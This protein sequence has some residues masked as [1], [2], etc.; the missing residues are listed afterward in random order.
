MLDY[1]PPI[2]NNPIMARKRTVK[3]TKVSEQLREAIR[4]A[5][6]SRYRISKETGIDQSMLTKFLQGERGLAIST[7]DTLAE[8]LNLE[9]TH[10]K[11]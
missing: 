10:K 3:S 4:N 9:L 1:A 7:I 2:G 5:D 8:F 11:G 6:C